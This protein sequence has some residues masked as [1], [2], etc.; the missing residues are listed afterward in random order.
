MESPPLTLLRIKRKRTEEPLDALLVQTQANEKRPRKENDKALS[1]SPSALPTFF[2]LAETVEEKGLK[3]AADAQKLKDRIAL[4]V[5]RIPETVQERKDRLMQQNMNTIREARYRVVQKNRNSAHMPDMDMFNMYEAVRED[6]HPKAPK[7]FPDED[8]AD[9]EDIMCNFIPMVKEYL[10]L[11]D[12]KQEEE[13]DYVYDVYYQDNSESAGA[14]K[15]LTI[16]SLIWFNEETQYM[17]DESDSEAADFDDEDSNAE[18]FYQNDYPDEESDEEFE[19]QY[20]YSSGDD[21]D[22]HYY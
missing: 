12:R 5:N 21:D 11:N 7:L 15:D 4:R 20:G 22:H 16:G 9:D 2:R 14:F 10:T 6:E 18:D 13:D 1:V 8:N 17:N 19:E 3:N